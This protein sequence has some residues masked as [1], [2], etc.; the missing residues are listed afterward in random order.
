MLLKF[1]I[2]KGSIDL[3]GNERT[4][5]VTCAVVAVW[6]VFGQ[7][8]LLIMSGLQAISEEIYESAEIEFVIR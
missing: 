6:Q 8:T 3:L 2:I 4:A 5:L 7:N 1:G